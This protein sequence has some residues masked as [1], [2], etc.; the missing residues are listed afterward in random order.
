[1]A[2]KRVKVIEETSWE[3]NE[4]T[5]INN[6]LDYKCEMCFASKV[7]SKGRKARRDPTIVQ[8]RVQQAMLE[9]EEKMIA[10]TLVPV[11]SHI[12]HHSLGLSRHHS[13]GLNHI[14]PEVKK[15]F[16]DEEMKERFQCDQCEA[17]F[18]AQGNLRRHKLSKHEQVRWECDLCKS[19]FTDQGNLRRH[20]LTK[21]EGATYDCYQCPAQFG[22]HGTLRRH[23]LTEHEGVRPPR[24]DCD[25]CEAQFSDVGNLR[26]HKM[27]KHEGVKYNC[28]QCDAEFSEQGNLK[29]HKLTKHDG[30]RYDCNQCEAR[31]YDQNTLKKHQLTKHEGVKIDGE[32]NTRPT[33]SYSCQI[34]GFKCG[35]KPNLK[36]HI[37]RR[38]CTDTLSIKELEEMYP[39]MY[40][41]HDP[42]LPDD[43]KGTT[44][45]MP[46]PQQQNPAGMK[47]PGMGGGL[48]QG[49][50]GANHFAN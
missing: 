5:Y 1:M 9:E 12:K 38:H 7:T 24:Y 13:L 42:N 6:P 37:K 47:Y 40:K 2:K 29:R 30:I 41:C 31:F 16:T 46:H 50:G 8:E 3:C 27:T 26:R 28:D 25:L 11:M 14:M 43:V 32:G 15:E 23:I 49:N 18:S 4:C 22:N 45:G 17:H 21:H 20:K 48:P 44:A 39:E 33:N 19:T 34:C 35:K 36:S 10:P